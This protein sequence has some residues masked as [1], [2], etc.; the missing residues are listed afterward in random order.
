MAISGGLAGLAGAVE[1]LAVHH[2]FLDSFS[3]GY[4]FDSIAVALL[5]GLNSLGITVS[6]LLF[7][8]L[9]SGS[10]AMESLTSTPRQIAGVVQA[11][12]ILAVGAAYLRSKN[13]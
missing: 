9:N 3:P 8:A 10:I 5:G 1:V 7:G 11:I 4:G 6:A 12:V 2:R 13:K